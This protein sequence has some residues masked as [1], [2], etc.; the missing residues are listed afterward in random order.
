MSNADNKAA[1]ARNA[2]LAGAAL[3]FA[4]PKPAVN[5]KSSSGVPSKER[6]AAAAAS[7]AHLRPAPGP[8]T[9]PALITNPSAPSLRAA[10]LVVARREQLARAGTSTESRPFSNLSLRPAVRPSSVIVDLSERNRSASPS[11]IAAALAA[12]RHSSISKHDTTPL[13]S[14]Q[15]VRQQTSEFPS[16]VDDYRMSQLIYSNGASDVQTWL[17]SIQPRGTRAAVEAD[18]GTSTHGR[19][20]LERSQTSFSHI[21]PGNDASG[22]NYGLDGARLS[23]GR[24]ARRMVSQP[25]RIPA[26][27][28]DVASPPK[29]D[30]TPAGTF[31]YDPTEVEST[32]SASAYSEAALTANEGPQ[33]EPQEEDYF[34][35][36]IHNLPP[37]NTT[38]LSLAVQPSTA[39]PGPPTESWTQPTD[40][41]SRRHSIAPTLRRYNPDL[42][43][44]TWA[45]TVAAQP[46]PPTHQQQLPQY[47]PSRPAS[48]GASPDHFPCLLYTSPSPR[49]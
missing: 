48:R 11:N 8:I 27:D 4:K 41:Q 32:Y 9:R 33:L 49:D 10:G 7:L 1:N 19:G 37:L 31:Q 39:G 28:I 14:P 43:L 45:S 29:N 16:S 47:Q 12:S 17:E 26:I 3:A 13:P 20:V 36:H 5:Q 40:T 22:Q 35:R 23:R 18:R 21:P 42:R 2:A 15:H 6:S 30:R 44:S 34:F 38:S 25:A 46:S 24:S